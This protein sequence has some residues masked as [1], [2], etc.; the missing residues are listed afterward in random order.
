MNDSIEIDEDRFFTFSSENKKYLY[1]VN[2]NEIFA[3]DEEIYNNISNKNF[4]ISTY[5]E[6]YQK[7]A[8]YLFSLKKKKKIRRNENKC[9]GS[10][11]FYM[12][13]CPI[14]PATM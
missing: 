12:G 11:L 3:V 8:S 10:S 14:L 9:Y 7:A 1:D 13:K 4:L 6:K 2:T 5:S